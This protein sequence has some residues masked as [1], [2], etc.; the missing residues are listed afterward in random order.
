MI[1]RRFYDDSLAQASYM[2]ACERSAEAIVIDPN[3]DVE[4]YLRAARDERVR[5]TA[6]TETHIHADF[7]SGA[8]ALA[9]ATG[10][11]LHVSGEGG[12]GWQYSF[13]HEPGVNIL[14][15]GDEITNG[16]V[17]LDVHHTPGHTPEH[18]TFVLT[19]R[20]RSDVP[21]GAV[22]GDFI[23][24]GDVGRP[25]LLERAAGLAGTMRNSAA[26]LY[27]SIQA[28]KRLPDHLQIWPGHGAGS[29]CGKAM[30]SAAQST[31][32]YERVANWAL[33]PMTESE[34]VD[35]VLEGQPPAPPY[36][37]AMKA[38]NRDATVPRKVALPRMMTSDEVAGLGVDDNALIV[39]VRNEDEWG[40][41][42]IQ[43][44]M[45][46]P[47]SSL[48][49]RLGEIPRDRAIV[50][51][52]QRGSRSAVAAATLDAFGYDDVHELSGGMS[53]WEAAGHPV[54]T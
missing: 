20:A 3:M 39:D 33:A 34:F 41:G 21:V 43:N 18:L 31:L 49:T 2:I 45:L 4:M 53:A 50:L 17:R 47:V 6:V 10:A 48:H 24:V 15:A 7:A 52:C 38:R 14:H 19:D 27:A 12:N 37:G 42:H 28:F 26:S 1:F 22:T 40:R 8:R 29:A 13:A 9:A 46:I 44:A 16:M 54:A 23:F 51:H 5:V 32:G 11:Q 36:F 30:S 35:R 25:D